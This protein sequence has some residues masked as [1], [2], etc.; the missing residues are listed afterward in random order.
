[1]APSIGW[2]PEKP[3][4]I[5]CQWVIRSSPSRQQRKIGPVLPQ[6]VEVHQ[7]GLEALEHAADRLEL[8]EIAVDPVGVAR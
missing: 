2:R 8:L 1:M 5:S 4:S 3:A 6:R 7:P